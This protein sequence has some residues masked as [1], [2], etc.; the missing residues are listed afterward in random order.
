MSDRM[1]ELE[2]VMAQADCL[3]TLVEVERALDAMAVQI[4]RDLADKYP[5]V[6]G[7]MTG[8]LSTMGY[9]LQRLPFLLEV[10][11]LHATRYTGQLQGSDVI[12][13]R[14]PAVSLEGRHVLLVDDILDR[15]ITL[16]AIVK[17]CFDHGAKDVRIAVLTEKLLENHSPSV[18]ADY[19][20]LQ[21]PDRYV[22]G[23][24][25]DYEDHWR[26]APGIFACK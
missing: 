2:G 19:V 8:A 17:Y 3:Y 1:Q 23:Y 25:M 5:L 4:N 15:G 13:K 20:A 22:F 11:Y 10:D 9:L 7:V 26:N 18:Q 12:W 16:A 14:Y 21:V 6:L 24:G